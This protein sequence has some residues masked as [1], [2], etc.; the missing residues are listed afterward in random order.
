MSKIC[1]F[2]STLCSL[3]FLTAQFGSNQLKN[4]G[5]AQQVGADINVDIYV[6]TIKIIK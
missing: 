2:I 3:T 6:S 4:Y 5:F 1:L